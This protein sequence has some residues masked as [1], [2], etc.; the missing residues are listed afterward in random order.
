MKK[1]ANHV[2]VMALKGI[3]SASLFASCQLYEPYT[4]EE[5]LRGAYERNFV[6]VY[7]AVDPANDW[8]FSDEVPIQK[9]PISTR[10]D[11]DGLGKIVDVDGFFVVDKTMTKT[12]T[13]Q[14]DTKVTDKGFAFLIGENDCFDIFPVYLTSYQSV[15]IYWALQMF[16]DNEAKI[17]YYNESYSGWR[18]GDGVYIKTSS[19]GN[20]T[21]F[22]NSVA[23]K[24]DGM[25]SK[26]II[27][28]TNS[29]SKKLM[30]LALVI[31]QANIDHQYA[32][33]GS[34]QSSLHKQM[35]ILDIPKP[36][37]FGENLET[38]FVACE[39]ADVGVYSPLVS[40]KRYQSLVLMIVGP[41]IPKVIY[42]RT[43]NSGQ[44]WIDCSGSSKR[45]MIEDLGSASDFDFN[46]IVVDVED[47]GRSTPILLVQ[48][49]KTGTQAKLTSVSFGTAQVQKARA[50]L[51]FLC[52]TRPFKLYVGDS[53]FG[54]VTDPTDQQQTRCQLL[55][56]ELEK[57]ATYFSGVGK[58][59]GWKPDT[60]IDIEGWTPTDNKVSVEVWPKG[61]AEDTETQGGWQVQ[62]PKVGAVPFMMAVPTSTPWSAEGVRFTDWQSFVPSVGN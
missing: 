15:N 51:R 12:I 49:N 29:G 44:G 45:Y 1:N 40:G 42:E 52:G 7:G 9:N 28:Y 4:Y 24:G 27:R 20:Y 30:H 19:T 22:S 54:L 8:D 31:S 46:D 17:P 35:R 59:T 11:A 6:H 38:L 60:Q 3:L 33:P 47:G 23:Y 57:E 34:M 37:N 5:V 61:N 32:Y 10:A 14:I 13:D 39:A 41:R 53:S 56:Q 2:C 18:M 50:T 21:K 62:F 26:S 36:A 43:D 16:V 25:C 55:N 58:I 48:N